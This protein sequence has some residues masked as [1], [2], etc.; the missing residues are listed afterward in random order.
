LE[1]MLA[2]QEQRQQGLEVYFTLDAGPTVHLLCMER[3]LQ[4]VIQFV[5]HVEQSKVDRT[6]N[7]LVNAPSP[8]ARV[9]V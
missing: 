6:W 8:G 5:K 7:I 1:L 4:Q 9:I 2:V 3:N